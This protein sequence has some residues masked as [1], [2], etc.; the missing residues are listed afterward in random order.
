MSP[1]GAKMTMNA[2]IAPKISRQYGK[3]DMTV[4][5]RKMKAKA[6]RSGPKNDEKPPNRTMKTI[7]P[8]WVQ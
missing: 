4:S 5:W 8:E 6:P 1:P 3:T 7:L 2:S